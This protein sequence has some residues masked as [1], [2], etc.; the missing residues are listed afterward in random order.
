MKIFSEKD[1]GKLY[2]LNHPIGTSEQVQVI[3]K[4]TMNYGS[5]IKVRMKDSL[6]FLGSRILIRETLWVGVYYLFMKGD[7]FVALTPSQVNRLEESKE[8]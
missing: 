4:E 2:F 8:K 5:K 3:D 1:I 6:I 7:C